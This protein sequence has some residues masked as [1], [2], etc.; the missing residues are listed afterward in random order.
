MRAMENG[1]SRRQLSP[2]WDDGAGIYHLERR[3]TG[4]RKR[5]RRRIGFRLR[6]TIVHHHPPRDPIASLASNYVS[7][8][9]FFF[10]FFFLLLFFLVVENFPRSSNFLV[11]S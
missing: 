3:E 2:G 5:R 8:L 6:A 1:K 9:I 10:F 11:I 4:P 7:D